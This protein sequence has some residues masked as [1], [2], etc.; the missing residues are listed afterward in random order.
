MVDFSL[1]SASSPMLFSQD[2]YRVVVM[3]MI[4]EKAQAEA[5]EAKAEAATREPADAGGNHS[6]KLFE[7]KPI[8]RE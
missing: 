6:R 8:L 1:A 3:P 7:I 4:T 2:N 5:K